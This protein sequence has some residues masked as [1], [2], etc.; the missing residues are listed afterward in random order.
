MGLL[1]KSSSTTADNITVCPNDPMLVHRE[2][3]IKTTDDF[4][5]YVLYVYIC[6]HLVLIEMFLLY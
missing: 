4:L 5:I 3:A 6:T 2:S 1:A